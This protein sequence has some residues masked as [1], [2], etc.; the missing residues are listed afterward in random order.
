MSKSSRRPK[1]EEIKAQRKERKRAQKA[2]REELKGKGFNISSHSTISNHKCEFGS[3]EEEGEARNEA[4]LEQL[5]VFRGKLPV[6]LRRLSKVPDPA[7]R[8]TCAATAVRSAAG[9]FEARPHLR[10]P[11]D[12]L[13]KSARA[14][15]HNYFVLD[16][17]GPENLGGNAPRS[18]ES[19]LNA[20]SSMDYV[21]PDIGPWP[22]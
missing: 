16:P 17:D 15:G 19:S 21:R 14:I 11:F 5:K 7:L 9:P 2:L 22:K 1:R 4:V 18:K 20:K 10:A 8:W 6:L 12:D 3:V 13:A